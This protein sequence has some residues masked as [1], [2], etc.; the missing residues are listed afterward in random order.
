MNI[1]RPVAYLLYISLWLYFTHLPSDPLI[2]LHIVALWFAFVVSSLYVPLSNCVFYVLG[3]ILLDREDVDDL[4]AQSATQRADISKLLDVTPP[5]GEECSIC[6]QDFTVSACKVLPCKHI[7]H[8][9]C[10]QQRVDHQGANRCPYC[11]GP[12]TNLDLPTH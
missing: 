9:A 8:T 5:A 6:W 12:L 2:I 1:L 11:R 10:L 3:R 7:Y 4:M